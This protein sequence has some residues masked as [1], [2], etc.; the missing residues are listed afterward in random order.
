MY[1]HGL[2]GREEFQGTFYSS[3]CV[4]KHFPFIAYTDVHSEVVV[5]PEEVN[6][7]LS[8][9]MDVDDDVIKTG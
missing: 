8:E 6:N 1:Q 3:A 2:V 4:E 7:L 5:V 9:M